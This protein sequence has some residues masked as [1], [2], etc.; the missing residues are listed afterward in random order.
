MTVSSP[1]VQS[2]LLRIAH[3]SS[4]RFKNFCLPLIT[5][6]N[7]QPDASVIGMRCFLM[8]SESKTYQ[9]LNSSTVKK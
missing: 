8:F 4:E 5:K 2:V 7:S 9:I 3:R 6:S 1:T